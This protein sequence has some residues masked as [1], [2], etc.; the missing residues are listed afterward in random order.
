MQPNCLEDLIS[1]FVSPGP[2]YS[3]GTDAGSNKDFQTNTSVVRSVPPVSQTY[4]T[5]AL[6][7]TLVHNLGYN[8]EVSV[9][10]SSGNEMIS[11][12]QSTDV[13]TVVVT[14][15]TATT[16]VILAR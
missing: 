10:D 13:N 12:V 4:S 6:V 8:P 3:Y 15:L 5:P 1:P 14:H 7:W 11:D 2:N 16:G 9:N